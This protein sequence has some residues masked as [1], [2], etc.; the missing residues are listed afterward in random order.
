MNGNILAPGTCLR[1]RRPSLPRSDASSHLS[2]I[3]YELFAIS[4]VDLN[5]LKDVHVA[6][7]FS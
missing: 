4:Y 7:S 3:R 6:K 1:H 5:D 2:D